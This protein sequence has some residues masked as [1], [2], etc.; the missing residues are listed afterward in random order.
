M[1]GWEETLLGPNEPLEVAL[2]SINASGRGIC[3]VVDAERRLLGTLSDGDVRRSIIDGATL[4][5]PCRMVMN[6]RPTG[7]AAG[8]SRRAILAALRDGQLR[9]LPILKEGVVVG[10]AMPTDFLSV[11]DRSN[12]VV[13]MAGGKGTR[14]SPLTLETPKPMLKVGPRPV[15]ETILRVFA[16]QGFRRF[17][18]STNYKAEQIE[19][20]FGDGADLGL[21]IEYLRETRALGTCGALG[22]MPRPVDMPFI[23][24]NADVLMQID[25][26]SLIE[27]HEE[28]GADLTVVVR[29]HHIQVPFGVVESSDGMVRSIVEKPSF[30]Y[31]VNAGLYVLSESALDLIPPDGPMDM[32]ELLTKML[33]RGFKVRSQRDDGYWIDIGHM[34]DYNRANAE[35]GAS[36]G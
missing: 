31:P 29:E 30:V 33:A 11:P 25:Y 35:F 34:S 22:L 18:L 14:L 24:A 20:Y 2:K 27:A 13:I 26:S 12:P 21:E 4:Q 8:T 1:R 23:V 16:E 15:L 9:H 5:T 28:A 6:S 36:F 17:Y 3:L 10:L 19:D 32:P 7:I